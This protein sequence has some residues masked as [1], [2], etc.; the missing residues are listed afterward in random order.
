[1]FN[2][3]SRKITNIYKKKLKKNEKTTLKNQ[4]E[5]HLIFEVRFNLLKSYAYF[6]M[7]ISRLLNCVFRTIGRKEGQN[8]RSPHRENQ[9]FRLSWGRSIL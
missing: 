1:M 3:A 2:S 5:K 7:V 6:H 9:N 8:K 4:K